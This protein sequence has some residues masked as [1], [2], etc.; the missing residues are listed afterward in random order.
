MPEVRFSGFVHYLD[1]VVDCLLGKWSGLE[2]I[3]D[4][5]RKP[6]CDKELGRRI[7]LKIFFVAEKMCAECVLGLR[8]RGVNR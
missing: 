5:E 1:E 4:T 2:N 6:D 3:L 8:I 7:I